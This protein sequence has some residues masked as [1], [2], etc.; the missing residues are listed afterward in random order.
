M[1]SS[2]GHCAFLTVFAA[3][4]L[5]T[6][7]VA[8]EYVQKNIT[9]TPGYK[10]LPGVASVPAPI[11]IAP[12]QEWWGVDGA[13]ST[14]S[15]AVGKPQVNVR[16]Q[17]STASQQ[18]WIVNQQ[19]CMQNTTNPDTKK[20]SLTLNQECYDA[21]G[22][23]YNQTASSSWRQKGYYQLW[24]EKKLGLSGNGLYGFDSVR[25]GQQGE[26][27]PFI[28]NTTLSTFVSSSFWIGNFGLHTKPTNFS[29]FE[30]PIPSHMTHLFEQK[31]IPSLSFGYT[32]GSRY[33]ELDSS[34]HDWM[35]C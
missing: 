11:S 4:A 23:L 24:L 29:A 15:L 5:L 14:F 35:T 32:A 31:N 19:A 9:N 28:P 27:G 6:P 21:R 17:V 8:A 30:E 1:L 22:R 10:L 13:W 12:D 18:I 33:R 16:L 34:V 7:C 3:L 25:F 20:V 2:R 26:E